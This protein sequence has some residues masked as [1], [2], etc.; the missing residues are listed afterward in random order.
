MKHIYVEEE[1]I[2]HASLKM[3]WIL[4]ETKMLS[5]LQAFWVVSVLF[6]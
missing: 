2:S 3:K 6:E 1:S 4:I 5:L